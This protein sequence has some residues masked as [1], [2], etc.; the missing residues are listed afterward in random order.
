MQG[1]TVKD[2]AQEVGL[3]EHTVSKYI[4]KSPAPPK[5]TAGTEDEALQL[6]YTTV[7]TKREEVLAKKILE[8]VAL[9]EDDVEG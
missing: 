8:Q 4:K 2:I 5:K 1:H 7:L 6:D 9:Y 3:H